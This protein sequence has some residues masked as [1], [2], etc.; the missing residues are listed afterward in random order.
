MVRSLAHV[1]HTHIHDAMGQIKQRTQKQG[2]EF[3]C[4]TINIVIGRQL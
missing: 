2:N 3:L 1:L 4:A